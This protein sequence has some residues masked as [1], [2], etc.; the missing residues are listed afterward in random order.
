MK[1]K[2]F[3]SKLGSLILVFTMLF[4]P[5]APVAATGEP[6]VELVPSL[7]TGNTVYLEMLID[8]IW[9]GY[10]NGTMTIKNTGNMQIDNWALSF[11]FQHSI[12][13]I[14]NAVIF[15]QTDG[16]YTVKNAG[17][18]QDIPV[19]GSV[20]FGF[21][22]QQNGDINTPEFYFINTAERT[23][24]LCDYEAKYTLYSDWGSG[25]NGEIALVNKSSQTIED[26]SLSMDFPRTISTVSNSIFTKGEEAQYCF[27]NPGYGQNISA[28]QSINISIQGTDGTAADLP[29]NF[30]LSQ[31]SVG[32]SLT[33]D[34]DA[35]GVKDYE[36]LLIY[37]TDPLVSDSNTEPEETDRVTDTDSD[38]IPDYYE[39]EIGTDPLL[40]D[41]DG[42]GI[43]DMTEVVLGSD[44]L[45]ADT[46]NDGILDGDVDEDQ[47]GLSLKQEKELGTY[48]FADD[49]DFDG[50]HDAD[51]VNTYGTDPLLDD[52]DGD[53][54][55]DGEEILLGKNP[56]S[57]DSDGD[58]ILDNEEKTSQT[59]SFDI[60][61]SE[62]PGISFVDVG[63]DLAHSIDNAVKVK[64]EYNNDVLST[65]IKSRI[66][67]PISFEC[68]EDFDR[69]TVVI[70]YDESAL[71]STEEHN[72][73]VLWYDKENNYYV[74]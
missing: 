71:G 46:D 14:W 4:I 30:T 55:L 66:G 27:D 58:G 64:D 44:P 49:S 62:C 60:S 42:D 74:V 72:L 54:I 24:P 31:I 2:T 51:E 12:T 39:A 16:M 43:D 65:G 38:G 26:W 56:L 73:G 7:I 45:L 29:S 63:M 34:Y 17:W 22:A 41:T 3:S 48:F 50:L 47:D 9:D 18:N 67:S 35:D 20:S 28:S 19:G 6:S 5:I 37:G 8:S 15:E 33:G 1:L 70:H 32:V 25:F 23:V 52:T 36:E 57:Q 11:A 10:F 68:E 21:T 40:A 53:T 69:A 61:S 59:K 13:N